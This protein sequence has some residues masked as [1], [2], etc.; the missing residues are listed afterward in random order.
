MLGAKSQIA[1][2]IEQ[3]IV[4]S[5]IL[6]VLGWSGTTWGAIFDE[7]GSKM[8][9]LTLYWAMLWHLGSKMARKNAKKRNLMKF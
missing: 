4:F 7:V 3:T 2:N 8:G 9:S 6:K 1:K 5:R